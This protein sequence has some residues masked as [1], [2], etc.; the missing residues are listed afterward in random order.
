MK[1][2]ND[3]IHDL[4]NEFC[5]SYSAFDPWTRAEGELLSKSKASWPFGFWFLA[6]VL[7]RFLLYSFRVSSVR[8]SGMYWEIHK[9][10][11]EKH[12]K[13]VNAILTH[14]WKCME[15]Q[16]GL[17][18]LR[19]VLR[20]LKSRSKCHSCRLQVQV[21]LTVES[22]LAKVPVLRDAPFSQVR[23]GRCHCRVGSSKDGVCFECSF[24]ACLALYYATVPGAV[25]LLR[26]NFLIAMTSYVESCLRVL[27]SL[28]N[29]EM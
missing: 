19:L 25:M 20:I 28:M 22:V 6:F 26:T 8:S 29:F 23:F 17:G 12:V 9:R 15:M 7:R 16:T 10:E 4:I 2:I 14:A 18:L 13:H 1:W 27:T 21:F 24:A 11:G 3:V 5:I